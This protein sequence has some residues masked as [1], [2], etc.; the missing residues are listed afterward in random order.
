MAYTLGQFAEMLLHV[1]VILPAEE[2]AAMEKAAKILE[3][4]AKG[5]IGIARPEWPPLAQATLDRKGG[6]NTPLL[7]TGEMQ[8]SIE[9]NSDRHEAYIGS[10]NPKLKWHEFGTVNV[11]W[12]TVNPPRPVLAL[13][14]VRKEKEVVDTIG[15]A[16][17]VAIETL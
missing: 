5:L 16:V 8:A 14:S 11:P 7:E 12:G 15:R 6:V 9:H 13:A 4:E 3:D 1:T 10:N 2:A 17:F